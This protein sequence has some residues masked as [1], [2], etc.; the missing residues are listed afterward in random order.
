MKKYNQ[1]PLLLAKGI[2]TSDYG[3]VL[4]LG[5]GRTG[6]T[7]RLI[8]PNVATL[9]SSVAVIGKESDRVL[10]KTETIRRKRFKQPIFHDI[11]SWSPLTLIS[12]STTYILSS[13]YCHENKQ[14]KILEAETA[15]TAIMETIY[16]YPITV[17]IDG[18]DELPIDKDLLLTALTL[19]KDKNLRLVLT[20]HDLTGLESEYGPDVTNVIIS[21]CDYKVFMG[22]FDPETYSA[23]E[24]WSCGNIKHP[25]YINTDSDKCIVF[26]H[27]NYIVAD[28]SRVIKGE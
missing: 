24:L 12:P 22:S 27:D 5:R 2:K 26:Y 3:H 20:A 18:V 9:R 15:L 14:D 6:K 10:E 17:F 7:E 25:E 11:A 19:D 16:P 28:K 21:G 1:Y 13:S 4:V 23:I 8:I